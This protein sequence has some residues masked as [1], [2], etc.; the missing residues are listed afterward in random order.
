MHASARLLSAMSSMSAPRPRL[1]VEV[2]QALALACGGRCLSAAYVNSR[3]KLIWQCGEQHEWRASLASIKYA[4]LLVPTVRANCTTRFGRCPSHRIIAWRPVPFEVLREWHISFSVA[5]PGRPRIAKLNTVRYERLWCP[6]CKRGARRR[7]R[8]AE[9][10]SLAAALGGQCLSSA[11]FGAATPLQWRC[12]EGYEW[13]ARMWNVKTGSW[14]PVCSG[15]RRRQLI[16]AQ[17]LAASHGG[18]CLSSEYNHL[19]AKLKWQCAFGHQWL[20]S[21]RNVK[22][23]RTWCPTCASGRSEKQ[24]RDIFQLIFCGYLFRKMR[25]DFL[26]SGNGR[27]LELDG[28]CP[29]LQ[30]AFEFQGEQHY[31]RDSYFNTLGSGFD[32]QLHRDRLKVKLCRL[33][34]VRLVVIPYC[35]KDRWTFVRTWLLAWFSIG[36]IFPTA[37]CARRPP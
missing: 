37:I 18:Q 12:R 21:L 10:Q 5:L 9:S 14:C 31:I 6:H 16:V 1:N 24:V 33:A 25:P 27:N 36:E 8:L 2:A 23:H 11:Y 26:A 32:A 13:Q 28:Y 35:V 34:G 7:Q 4:E 30:L 19:R 3:D 29:T 15:V 17:S 22:E 20:S